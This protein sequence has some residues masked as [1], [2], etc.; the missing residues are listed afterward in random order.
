MYLCRV[1]KGSQNPWRYL[2][3]IMVIIGTRK[4]T[5]VRYDSHNN[6]SDMTN[7]DRS[8]IT[9]DNMIGSDWRLGCVYVMGDSYW[10]YLE[11]IWIFKV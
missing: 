11:G 10:S 7:F 5:L 8:K 9:T 4:I 6:N 3:Q 2:A 1:W